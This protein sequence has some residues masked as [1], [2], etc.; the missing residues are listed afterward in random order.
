MGTQDKENIQ[1]RRTFVKT[2][3]Y[4]APA[5]LTLRAIPAFATPGSEKGNNGCGNGLDPQPPGTPPPND[6]Q[7]PEN[8]PE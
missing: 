6:T 5:I 8:C 7:L 1:T 4:V 2:A 3:A